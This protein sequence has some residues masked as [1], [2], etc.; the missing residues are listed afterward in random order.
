MK[1]AGC[2]RELDYNYDLIWKLNISLLDSVGCQ[3]FGNPTQN[4][5]CESCSEI[6]KQ[7]FVKF[8]KTLVKFTNQ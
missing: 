6:A 2:G 8:Q 7:H 1:C 4:V 5:Y 3:I